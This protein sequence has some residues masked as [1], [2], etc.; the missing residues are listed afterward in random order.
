MSDKPDLARDLSSGLVEFVELPKLAIHVGRNDDFA[1]VPMVEVKEG[2]LHVCDIPVI[3]NPFLD[4]GAYL[5]SEPIKIRPPVIEMEPPKGDDDFLVAFRYLMEWAMPKP[6]RFIGI[7]L[8]FDDTPRIRRRCRV[9]RCPARKRRMA[10]A[11]LDR[12][13]NVRRKKRAAE[14]KKR[15]ESP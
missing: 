15:K 9:R 14:L 2:P 11:K 8:G 4:R 3:V 6:R 10:Q 12:E 13:S 5:M 1:K 7:D